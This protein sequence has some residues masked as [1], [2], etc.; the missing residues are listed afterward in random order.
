MDGA[1]AAI[2]PPLARGAQGRNR[3]RLARADALP[4]LG[5]ARLDVNSDAGHRST[6]AAFIRLEVPLT[7]SVL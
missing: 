2:S 7:K 6:D 1:P 5:N 3:P 4:L